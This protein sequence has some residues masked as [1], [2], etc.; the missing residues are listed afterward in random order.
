MNKKIKYTLLGQLTTY[1]EQVNTGTKLCAQIMCMDIYWP[2]VREI[3]E[4][5]GCK[6][7]YRNESKDFKV[8]YI[9][10]YDF[11]ELIIDELLDSQREKPSGFIV[12]ATGKLFG[13]SDYE[14]S[15]YLE[16]HGYLNKF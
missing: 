5:E 14:I 7:L 4:Q 3:I 8:I 12:W 6:V 1:C 2:F 10:K 11:V 13:Y 16:R 9:Y 15:E